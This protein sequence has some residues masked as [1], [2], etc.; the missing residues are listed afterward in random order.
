M[1]TPTLVQYVCHG[2]RNE[3]TPAGTAFVAPLPNPSLANNCLVL[4]LTYGHGATVNSVQDDQG[5]TWYETTAKA[6]S[7]AGGLV[8]TIYYAPNAAANT[9][10]V[11]VTF[12]ANCQ[13]IHIALSEWNNV[14]T[15]SPADGA[16]ASTTS[17][18][19]SITTGSF[20]PGTDG[21]LILNYACCNN[22]QL[23][24]F[25]PDTL[26]GT[27]LTAITA[28][29]NFT[30][31]FGN[32]GTGWM[33]Q[34]YVQ[35]SH[36]SINPS[37]AITGNT[38]AIFNS[39]ALALK[40]ASAG[41]A[42]DATQCRIVGIQHL[43]KNDTLATYKWPHY[44]AGN[45]IFVVT[46]YYKAAE[47]DITG[48]ADTQSNDYHEVTNANTISPQGWYAGAVSQAQSNVVTM[49]VGSP[50]GAVVFCVYDIVNAGAYDTNAFHDA[51]SVSGDPD[52]PDTP[53]ITPAQGGGVVIACAALGSGPCDTILNEAGGF[54]FDSVWFSGQDDTSAAFDSGDAYAHIYPTSGAQLSFGWSVSNGGI[55]TSFQATAWSFKA[56]VTATVT[57]TATEAMTETDVVN[58]GKT[59]IIT[60][61]NDTWIPAST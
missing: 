28:G 44:S 9:R 48:I 31:L 33:A 54:C 27:N 5:N 20:T 12:A 58:G 40:S 38:Q 49:T 60:L 34:F 21:S 14:A 50:A 23:S 45:L 8:T 56:L 22:G 57:G 30:R 59:I 46:S 26:G 25:Y 10:K 17:S 6:D 52:V 35:P 18:G 61:G 1:A 19:T 2:S 16:V 24:E 3:T 43:Y 15:V 29:T 37:F 39:V 13:Y 36:V 7:G 51:G 42:P 47:P 32:F 55:S 41:T 11:T 4:F 53:L